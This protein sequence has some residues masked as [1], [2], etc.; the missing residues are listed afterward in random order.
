MCSSITT[1]N[2]EHHREVVLWI[3]V[4]VIWKQLLG[5]VG[6]VSAKD[7]SWVF[8]KCS[9]C[10]ILFVFSIKLIKASLIIIKKHYQVSWFKPKSNL[11]SK[12]LNPCNCHLMAPCD[13]TINSQLWPRPSYKDIC[14]LVGNFSYT[15]VDRIN[16]ISKVQTVSFY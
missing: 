4:W 6:F 11:E 16:N 8:R 10:K 2:Y 13:L 5:T 15:F 7:L 3:P 14:L 9:F 1:F 12:T